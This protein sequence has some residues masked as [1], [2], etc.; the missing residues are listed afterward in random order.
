MAIKKIEVCNMEALWNRMN[1]AVS[2][3]C[4]NVALDSQEKD[5]MVCFGRGRARVVWGTFVL[6]HG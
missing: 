1:Q 2:N 4:L 3:F 5:K 6:I